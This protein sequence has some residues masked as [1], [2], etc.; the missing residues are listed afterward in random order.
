MQLLQDILSTQQGLYTNTSRL[1][2]FGGRNTGMLTIYV[3]NNYQTVRR[4]V[5]PHINRDDG[6]FGDSLWE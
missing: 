3:P 1:R 6:R 5:H 4:D 2:M